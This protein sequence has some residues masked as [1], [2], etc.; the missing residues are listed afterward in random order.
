MNT[1]S[2]HSNNESQLRINFTIRELANIILLLF[3]IFLPFQRLIQEWFILPYYFMWIDEIFIVT[4]SVLFIPLLFSRNKINKRVFYVFLIIVLFCIA[5]IFS[6]ILNQSRFIVT[7]LGA[8]DYVKKFF[9][10]VFF[11]FLIMA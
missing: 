10:I 5:S 4:I 7:I 9:P 2:I 3:L 6:G 11:S 1:D 8:F